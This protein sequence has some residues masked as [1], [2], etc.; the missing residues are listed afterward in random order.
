MVAPSIR[1]RDLPDWR[2]E[3]A[4]EWERKHGTPENVE[5]MIDYALDADPF[6]LLRRPKGIDALRKAIR[7]WYESQDF[8]DRTTVLSVLDG[9]PDFDTFCTP[10]EDDGHDHEAHRHAGGL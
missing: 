4:D 8:E 7:D 1:G 6:A 3:A 5:K 10:D 2:D 9:V